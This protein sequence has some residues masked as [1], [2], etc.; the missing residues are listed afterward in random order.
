MVNETGQLERRSSA[1]SDHHALAVGEGELVGYATV[2]RV[3]R[4]LAHLG[5]SFVPDRL[6]Q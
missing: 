3:S 1:I 2:L 4:N 6:S 5:I